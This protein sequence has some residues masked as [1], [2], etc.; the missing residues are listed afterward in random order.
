MSYTYVVEF[1]IREFR[2]SG[3]FIGISI[4]KDGA[5]KYTATVKMQGRGDVIIVQSGGV[6]PINSL[7]KSI[8]HYIIKL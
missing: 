4:K 2:D 3:I 1:L 6:D 8:L 5:D 7:Y